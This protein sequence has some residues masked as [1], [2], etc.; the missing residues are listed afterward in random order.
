MNG[1]GAMENL[2]KLKISI[3]G[4][5]YERKQYTIDVNER[6]NATVTKEL[7]RE[8]NV[9]DSYNVILSRTDTAMLIKRI[10]SWDL[11]SWEKDYLDI[12]VLDGEQWAVEYKLMGQR[13]KKHTGSNAYPARWNNVIATLAWLDFNKA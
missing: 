11:A 6:G 7:L 8:C 1:S 3:G 5:F 2:E 13:V 4:C 9:D 10:A 12:E